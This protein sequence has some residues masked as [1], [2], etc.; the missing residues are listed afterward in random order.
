VKTLPFKKGY[1]GNIHCS[2]PQCQAHSLHLK[3]NIALSKVANKHMHRS[4]D[5]EGIQFSVGSWW[6][7]IMLFN[8]IIKWEW[9]VVL[10]MMK[11]KDNWSVRCV[12]WDYAF[13]CVS[14]STI[15]RRDSVTWCGVWSLY[16]H[17]A[18]NYKNVCTLNLVYLKL[19][20]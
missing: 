13:S 7:R 9:Y 3:E 4:W 19:N 1:T 8:F 12:T 18:D 2:L 11:L 20:I 17:Q 10:K 6:I 14:T 15:Q 16:I 5:T